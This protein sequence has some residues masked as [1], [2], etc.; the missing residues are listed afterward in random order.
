MSDR[1]PERR[2]ADANQLLHNETLQEAFDAVREDIVRVIEDS[3]VTD[4]TH[5]EKLFLS[6]SLLQRV[7][8]QLQAFADEGKIRENN[9]KRGLLN[10]NGL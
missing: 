9:R 3:A 2:A 5:R 1:D 10:R 7:K 8:R 6:L 4:E